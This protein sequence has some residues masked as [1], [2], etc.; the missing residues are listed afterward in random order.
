MQTIVEHGKSP[1]KHNRRRK[2]ITNKLNDSTIVFFYENEYLFIGS[3]IKCNFNF[4]SN[5]RKCNTFS[6]ELIETHTRPK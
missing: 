1:K 4:K 3:R 2:E 5:Y 6:L